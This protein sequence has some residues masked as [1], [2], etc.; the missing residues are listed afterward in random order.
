MSLSRSSWTGIDGC[1]RYEQGLDGEPE[2]EWLQKRRFEVNV[3]A[4]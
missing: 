4:I 1:N 3:I 2:F